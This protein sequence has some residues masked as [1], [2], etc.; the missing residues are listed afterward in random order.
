MN[1]RLKM[2]GVKKK[3]LSSTKNTGQK[4]GNV[5]QHRDQRSHSV[6]AGRRSHRRSRLAPLRTAASRDHPGDPARRPRRPPR[7]DSG[8]RVR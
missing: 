5:L 2:G 4:P 6:H 7:Q 3:T 8:R 1:D